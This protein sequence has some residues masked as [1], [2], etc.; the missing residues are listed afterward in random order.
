MDK[1]ILNTPVRRPLFLISNDDG[2]NYGGI[3][4]LI[5]VARQLGDVVVVAPGTH[6]SGMASAIT[7]TA[8][9]T[10]GRLIDEPGFTVWTVNGTPADCVKLACDQLLRDRLPDL[11]LTGI[12]HGFNAG[13]STIYSGT[14][15]CAF[16]GLAHGLPSIAF[17]LGSYALDA[18]FSPC[19]PYIRRI[20]ERVLE[21][22]MPAGVCL[23]VNFPVGEILGLRVTTTAMGRWINEYEH[24]VNPSGMDYYWIQGD[25][26]CDDP[27]DTATDIYWLDRGWATVTPCHLDQT[28]HATMS[29]ISELLL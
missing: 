10:A 26:R 3:Q 20:V 2:Y 8:P 23:N 11:V 4:A 5:A 25:Y 18:D 21:F 6:Q 14:M 27:R 15:G 1:E 19:V 9:V 28:D 22:G 24:R 13:L 12:N 7:T 16:E 17:S 29:Q